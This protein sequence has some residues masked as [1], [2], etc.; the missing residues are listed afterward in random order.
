ML[1]LAYMKLANALHASWHTICRVKEKEE[2]NQR[3]S[4][5]NLSPIKTNHEKIQDKLNKVCAEILDLLDQHLIRKA[6]T[7]ETHVFSYG[8]KGDFYG[9]KAQFLSGQLWADCAL[10]SADAYL[11]AIVIGNQL[12]SAHPV[13]LAVFL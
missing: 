13:R 10:K 9:Y 7:T 6:V 3:G 11:T 1:Q 8:M 12:Q 4:E 5:D 2:R